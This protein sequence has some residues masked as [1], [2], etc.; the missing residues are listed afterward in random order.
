MFGL[1]AQVNVPAPVQPL[2]LLPNPRPRAAQQG[3][4]PAG[5]GT[6]GARGGGVQQWGRFPNRLPP[7]AP[8]HDDDGP[9][10]GEKREGTKFWLEFVHNR[11]VF[12]KNGVQVFLKLNDLR[13]GLRLA[14]AGLPEVNG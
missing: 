4:V 6:A 5:P 11:R 14:E 10:T 9:Q 2:S 7:P 8:S 13:A 1:E 3:P 12:S